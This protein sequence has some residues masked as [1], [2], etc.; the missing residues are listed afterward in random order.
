M[1]TG[2][3]D[4]G[5]GYRGIFASGVFDY[6]MEQG[7]TFD[8]G[9]GVSAGCA[10]L[11]SFLAGQRGRNYKFMKE[12]GQRREYASWHNFFC[13]RSFLDMDYIY[14]TLGNS[15][16]EYPLDYPALARNPMELL[17]VA[18]DALTGEAVY[19]QKSD[20]AQD[21]Y[22]V[23]K[24]SCSIPFACPPYPVNGKPYYDGA[25]S[26]PIPVGKAFAMGCE[27]VV[28]VLT[29]PLNEPRSPKK[30][31]RVARL[32]RRRYPAAAQ[33]LCQRAALYNESIALARRYEEDGR[34]IF[35]AP[36]DTCGVDTLTKDPQRL[37]QLYRKGYEAARKVCLAPGGKPGSQG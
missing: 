17:I 14:N 20:L 1:R 34:L 9:I 37:E 28:L 6:F 33:K 15:D 31:E 18:T 5:G 4:V 36:D 35:I 11:C 22:D 26:D 27:K 25:L 29:R 3:I 13:K 23:M 21:E 30:D 24:A 2:V 19:F 8:V 12:Y 16:G 32:I 7:I 10:N